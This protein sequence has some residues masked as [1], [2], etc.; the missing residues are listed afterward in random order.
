ML[1]LKIRLKK[2]ARLRNSELGERNFIYPSETYIVLSD[3]SED[4]RLLP[5]IYDWTNQG[6]SAVMFEQGVYWVLPTDIES[7]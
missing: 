3:W 1:R 7:N 6:L 4:V 5:E 2:G